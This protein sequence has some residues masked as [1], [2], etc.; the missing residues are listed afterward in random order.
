V[1]KLTATVL[2]VWTFSEKEIQIKWS[3]QFL[4]HK[5]KPDL[6][7]NWDAIKAYKF[8]WSFTFDT[9]KLITKDGTVLKYWHDN[10]NTKDD[11]K[12]FTNYFISRVKQHNEQE[13]VMLDNN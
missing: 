7:I 8:G 6:T 12:K 4:F 13:L 2:T 5:R 1:T 9:F 3:K 11:F 10:F